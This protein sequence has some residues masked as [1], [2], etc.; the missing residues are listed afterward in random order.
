MPTSIKHDDVVVVF[1][2]FG[3]AQPGQPVLVE[4]MQEQQRGLLASCSIVVLAYAVG[5]DV[6]FAPMR[7]DVSPVAKQEHALATLSP[8]SMACFRT[9]Q[10][11][12]MRACCWISRRYAARCV[13]VHAR[14]GS[15]RGRGLPRAKETFP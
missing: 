5:E 6:I 12:T 13:R 7:R 2:F 4:A 15:I 14:S 1:E 8:L 11:G 9:L 3:D 10:L